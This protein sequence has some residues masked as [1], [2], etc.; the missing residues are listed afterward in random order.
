M[1]PLPPVGPKLMTEGTGLH[2]PFLIIIMSS[3][4][5]P[6]KR[7]QSADH[8]RLGHSARTRKLLSEC[9]TITRSILTVKPLKSKLAPKASPAGATKLREHLKR[10]LQERI[11][12]AHGALC[13]YPSSILLISRCAAFLLL[14][15]F[16]IS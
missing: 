15:R 2:T 3:A 12:T 13:T 4:L 9:R 7:F 14:F 1:C 10:K 16:P 5:G 6:R 8:F 11:E